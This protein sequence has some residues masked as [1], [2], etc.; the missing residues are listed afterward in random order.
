MPA[1]PSAQKEAGGLP[2]PQYRLNVDALMR[3][4]PGMNESINS[5]LRLLYISCGSDDGLITSN[6]Q[7]EDWLTSQNIHSV[8]KEVPGYAHVWSFWRRSLVEVAPLLFR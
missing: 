1:Q 3:D 8:H 7:F 4:V 6:L 2:I 5:K